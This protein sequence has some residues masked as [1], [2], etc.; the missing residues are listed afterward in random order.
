MRLRRGQSAE[1]PTPQAQ[2]MYGNGLHLPV[3]PAMVPP[4]LESI[5][6]PQLP[7]ADADFRVDWA[8]VRTRISMLPWAPQRFRGT[9]STRVPV[10]SDGYRSE[11][12]E[13]V[14]LALSLTSDQPTYRVVELGAGWA[15]WAVMGIVCARRLGKQASGI[16]V[17]ADALRASWAMQH[18][19][20]NDVT[21]ELVT[22]DVATIINHLATPM[23]T[24]L[25]VVQAAAW[26]DATTLRFP[27]LPE[28]DM[29]G[30]ASAEVDPA[31]DYRGAHLDHVE[32]P[33]ITLR[34]VL[35][36]T[37]PTDLLHVDLQGQ[38]AAVLLPEA[39]LVAQRVRFMVVGTH[40]RLVEGLLQEA[41]LAG[42]WALLMESPSTAFFDGVKPTLTGFTTH[43][44]NQIWAN[45]RFRDAD[46]RIIRRRSENG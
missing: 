2:R 8:G 10:P 4:I 38:E 1:A 25:R 21:A 7:S 24:Q 29:G 39:E 36:A 6:A 5:R 15:P 27:V 12:E 20:D 28:D 31:M 19:A 37:Q 43:D 11:A 30:A 45:S 26:T 22:G 32:V 16:A 44:G 34:D 41:F 17:E 18:A 33:A 23:T 14:A 40:N 46:P 9:T 35:S 3:L 42:E 13:Y